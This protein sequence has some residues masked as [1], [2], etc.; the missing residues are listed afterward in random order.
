M[1]RSEGLPKCLKGE[2]DSDQ[3]NQNVIKRGEG[4]DLFILDVLQDFGNKLRESFLYEYN[5]LNGKPGAAKFEADH[6]LLSPYRKVKEK[7]SEIESLPGLNKLAQEA[8]AEL[9]AI[10]RHVEDMKSEW[11]RIFRTS[12][13]SAQNRMKVDFLRK[14]ESGPDVPHLSHLGDIPEIRASY[15]YRHLGGTNPRFAFFVAFDVLCQIKAR[16]SKGTILR[17]EF[18]E[19][20]TVPKIAVRTLSA[21]RSGG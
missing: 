3:W 9:R 18:A 12:S 16:E 8:R 2:E 10:E 17:R 4:L 21:L 14:F 1:L 15:A 20:V 19:L 13:K 5:N 11:P 7:L 6:D